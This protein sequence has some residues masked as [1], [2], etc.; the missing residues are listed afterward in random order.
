M[1]KGVG[2]YVVDTGDRMIQG[3]GKIITA[4]FKARARFPKPKR[5]RYQPPVFIPGK[6]IPLPPLKKL[7]T[8]ESQ[9]FRYPLYSDPVEIHLTTLTQTSNY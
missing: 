3:V 9:R 7:D 2:S 6:L 8:P 1:V 4:P 5:Y